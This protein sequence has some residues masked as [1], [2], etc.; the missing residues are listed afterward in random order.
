MGLFTAGPK[1]R[2]RRPKWTKAVGPRARG[3]HTGPCGMDSPASPDSARRAAW[4]L[5]HDG[6]ARVYRAPHRGVGLMHWGE[7]GHRSTQA[8]CVLGY[9]LPGSNCQNRGYAALQLCWVAWPPKTW[10]GEGIP[11]GVVHKR[12]G[13]MSKALVTNNNLGCVCVCLWEHLWGGGP[14]TH[15]RPP[16]PLCHVFTCVA[17]Q[18]FAAARPT[19]IWHLCCT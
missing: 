12:E 9:A 3:T 4:A 10:E 7:R 18:H 15:P 16:L 6:A 17:F 11:R 13:L 5:N 14:H 19:I 1:Q 2:A 8:A